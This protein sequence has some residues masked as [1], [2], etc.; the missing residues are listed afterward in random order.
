MVIIGWCGAAWAWD[1][2][3]SLVGNQKCRHLKG[4]AQDFDGEAEQI[5]TLA[6]RVFDRLAASG[7][8]LRASRFG[9]PERRSRRK[10]KV[11]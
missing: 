8:M 7:M 1:D 9:A 11:A 4:V 3:L 5:V 6:P 2:P 10:T